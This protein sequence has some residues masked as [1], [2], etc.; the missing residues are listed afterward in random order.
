MPTGPVMDLVLR[1][2]ATSHSITMPKGLGNVTRGAGTC[3]RKRRL[4]D[5][6]RQAL[7]HWHENQ[8]IVSA[9]TFCATHRPQKENRKQVAF[10]KGTAAGA[11]AEIAAAIVAVEFEIALE[12]DL[13]GGDLHTAP[14]RT[15]VR[16]GGNEPLA[17]SYAV[18]DWWAN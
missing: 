15:T 5:R 6:F 12:P 18:G 7:P 16:R 8:A 2:L 9:E 17:P 3:G 1:H 11:E 10:S 14:R 13:V 4:A